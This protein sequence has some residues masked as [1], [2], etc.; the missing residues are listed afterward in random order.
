M[1]NSRSLICRRMS[2]MTVKQMLNPL[3]FASGGASRA[4]LL[5]SIWYHVALRD[6][7]LDTR[8]PFDEEIFPWTQLELITRAFWTSPSK[9]N[10][11]TP[12]D[13]TD[14]ISSTP[15]FSEW[16]QCSTVSL[17]LNKRQTRRCILPRSSLLAGNKSELPKALGDVP[18]WQ[19]T[20][21]TK[22]IQKNN[23]NKNHSAI[24]AACRLLAHE[25]ASLMSRV[26]RFVRIKQIETAAWLTFFPVFFLS[27]FPRWIYF[28]RSKDKS[29][30]RPY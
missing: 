6:V 25:D 17:T 4:I 20:R 23:D 9:T 15:E 1:L 28:C 16:P 12:S 5:P 18:E 30:R 2:V 24:D 21:F 8:S 13:W 7:R 3:K 19:F 10:K 27:F 26:A 29:Q 11:Q 22:R 14:W